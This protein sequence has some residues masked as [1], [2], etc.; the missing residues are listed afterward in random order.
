MQTSIAIDRD[1]VSIEVEF[2]TLLLIEIDMAAITTEV[3]A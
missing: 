1:N 3:E 2:E